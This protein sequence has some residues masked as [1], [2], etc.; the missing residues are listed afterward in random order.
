MAKR[1][2]TGTYRRVSSDAA[3]ARLDELLAEGF[4]TYWIASAAG[5][6]DNSIQTA[7]QDEQATG[8]RRRF[9]AV[10]AAAI[11]N[12]DMS[13][14]TIGRRS[15]TGTRRRLQALAVNGWGLQHLAD[16][17]DVPMTTLHAL[18]NGKIGQTRPAYWR[19]VRDIYDE[20]GD[21]QGPNRQA[22]DKASRLGWLPPFAW[23]EPDLDPEPPGLN[24]DAV[25]QVAVDRVMSGDFSL[26]RTLRR[27]ERHAV[28]V[29]W[30]EDG[31][32]TRSLEKA[33]GWNVV[34]DRH[35]LGLTA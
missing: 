2:R 33:T 30:L 12:A 32:S 4:S 14:A 5:L 7:L 26:A 6:V 3:W 23:D 8:S 22:A 11:V 25:D 35:A 19:A 9:G 31:R 27:P 21:D 13:T 28:I 20:L 24:D 34:R 10:I 17:T 18:R 29:A 15:A 1:Q 16:L